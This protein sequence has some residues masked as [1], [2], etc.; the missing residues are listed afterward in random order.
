[1]NEIGVLSMP[2]SDERRDFHARKWAEP[3]WFLS[4]KW[5]FTFP[6]VF[7]TWCFI[8]GNFAKPQIGVHPMLNAQATAHDVEDALESGEASKQE[9]IEFLKARIDA[10][11][12]KGKFAS[13]PTRHLYEELTGT[14]IMGSTES[15][16]KTAPKLTV[17][18]TTPAPA[19]PKAQAPVVAAPTE[20]DADA[21]RASCEASSLKQLKA[22]LNKVHMD[23][24]RVI[25]EQVIASKEAPAQVQAQAPAEPTTLE[26]I[27]TAL[28]SDDVAAK[29]AI[30]AALIA[31]VS[32]Q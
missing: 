26:K 19:K 21:Y 5:E 22:R 9:A 30:L 4:R 18:P 27:Q 10:K 11:T 28:D 32:A 24:K 6:C 7:K 17:V 23:H 31:N 29:D 25:L 14:H 8:L 15:K 2:S 13:Y 16:S 3:N 1:M 20:F 12:A